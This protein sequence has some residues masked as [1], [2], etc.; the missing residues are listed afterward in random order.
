MNLQHQPFF[1]GNT[2]NNRPHHSNNN[3][4]AGAKGNIMLDYSSPHDG[5]AKIMKKMSQMEGS[6]MGSSKTIKITQGLIIFLL[7]LL[8]ISSILLN[9]MMGNALISAQASSFKF[10]A[11]RKTFYSALFNGIKGD[12]ELNRSFDKLIHS[13]DNEGDVKNTFKPDKN[14]ENRQ[15]EQEHELVNHIDHEELLSK[16]DKIL[17]QYIASS[18]VNLQ[19]LIYKGTQVSAI[20]ESFTNNSPSI[21]EDTLTMNNLEKAITLF[22]TVVNLSENTD[23]L[24]N[25]E[26]R[27]KL[28]EILNTA[29]SMVPQATDTLEIFK[30]ITGKADEFLE[31]LLSGKQDIK[32]KV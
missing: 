8:L 29:S 23:N 16:G 27:Q 4:N 31:K 14:K 6:S 12:P 13:L 1:R 7:I 21:I 17:I 3:N 32:I 22:H 19:H 10:D 26:N 11:F 25:E 20:I 24:L 30:N 2:N 28:E 5:D 15:Q 9:V 18:V